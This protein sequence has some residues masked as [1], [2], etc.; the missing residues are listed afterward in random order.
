LLHATGHLSGPTNALGLQRA[1]LVLLESL[2]HHFGG[3][4][5]GAVGVFDAPGAPGRVPEQSTYHGAR[6]LDTRDR[7]ADDVVGELIRQHATPAALTV[8]SD[9]HRVREAARRRRCR[10][11]SCLDFFEMLSHRAAQAPPPD[12]EDAK[13][14]PTLSPEDEALLRELEQ[15]QA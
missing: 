12:N 2:R 8:V 4:D 6:V 10:M 15:D 11:M 3:S 7:E 9:D 13:P 14:E 1:R 5:G